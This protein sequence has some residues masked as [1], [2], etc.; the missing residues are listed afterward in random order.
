MQ[1]INLINII[2]LGSWNKRIFSPNWVAKVLFK[3]GEPLEG[4]INQDEVELGYK[5]NGITV[6]PKDTVLE[7]AIDRLDLCAN[8]IDV[9]NQILKELPHTPIKAIGFNIRYEFDQS[10][11]LCGFIKN[12]P[13]FSDEF[14]FSSVKYVKH[15]SDYILNIDIST[16]MSQEDGG[17]VNFNY[18]YQSPLV[19]SSFDKTLFD[20]L[21]SESQQYLNDEKI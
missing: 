5:C 10:C 2:A 18:H 12:I 3:P 14:D 9:L 19:S 7:I 8:G 4:L 6:F 16:K 11:P 1:E 15:S 20:S 13:V 17:L 21:Y